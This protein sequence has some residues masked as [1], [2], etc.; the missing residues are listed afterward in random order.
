[1]RSV[2]RAAG[3]QACKPVIT[4]ISPV[5]KVSLVLVARKT[6]PAKDVNELIA[7]LK[8]NPGKASAGVPLGEGRLITAFFQKETGTQLTLVP[9][10]GGPPIIQDLMAGQIDLFFGGRVA[11]E[12]V[13]AGTIRAYAVTSDTRLPIAPDIPTF[14][15]MGLPAL[16]YSPW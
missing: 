13:Q 15:E 4:G 7:W 10:R 12:Q 2:R 5:A 3:G 6:I 11:L 1:M 14:V 8:A 16:S 9:Y